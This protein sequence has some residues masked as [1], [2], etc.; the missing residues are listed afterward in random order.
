MDVK[1]TVEQKI[2]NGVMKEKK[3]NLDISIEYG[4]APFFST[5][6]AYLYN[7]DA[8]TLKELIPKLTSELERALTI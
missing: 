3:Y 7:L 4:S 2:V 6:S 1:I 8:D 5:K